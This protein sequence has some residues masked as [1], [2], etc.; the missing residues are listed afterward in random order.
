MLSRRTLLAFTLTGACSA[1]GA[2]PAPVKPAPASKPAPAPARPVPPAPVWSV[3]FS[4]DGKLLAA[5]GYKQIALWDL[6]TQTAKPL[7]GHAGPVRCLAWS[8]D[9]SRLAGGGGKPGELGEVK[10]WT[11]AGG[12]ASGTPAT[13]REHRD[14]VEGLVFSPSGAV[15]SAGMDDRALV[16]PLA[17]GKASHQMSDHTGR[18]VSV[19]FSASGKY[20]ATGSLDS[21]VKIW[22][23][24]DYKPLANLDRNGGQVY[25]LTFL[26]AGDQLLVGGEDGNVRLYRLRETRSGKLTGVNGDIVRTFNGNRTPVFTVAA[27]PKGTLVAW[28]GADKIVHVYDSAS[29]NRKYTLK[30]SPEAVYGL[31]FSPDGATLAAGCR[32]G[33]VRLW[34]MADGKAAAE[35]AAN[36]RE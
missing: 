25:A 34:S 13:I 17:S 8:A 24:S 11:I 36:G 9:G 15:V 3:A 30:D 23:A 7:A 18:V 21:T 12:A 4:P 33:K 27:A 26:P 14:F 28:A 16:V 29:G 20:V 6:A 22:G 19:A 10:V 35:L 1:V 2:A 31:A 5:G 32:D